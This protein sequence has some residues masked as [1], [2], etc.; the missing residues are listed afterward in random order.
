MKCK[1]RV[2]DIIGNK[3][4]GENH[5]LYSIL[6]ISFS[7]LQ[8]LHLSNSMLPSRERIALFNALQDNIR[9]NMLHIASNNISDACDAITTAL[10]ENSSLV[11]LWIYHNP[12]SD[13]TI[14]NIVKCLY[15]G[16]NRDLQE[17]INYKRQS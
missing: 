3:T 17:V 6:S 4:V 12:L 11:K 1:V 7:M 10:V 5:Q 9:F 14:L 8:Y 16:D 13:N 2:L 15:R